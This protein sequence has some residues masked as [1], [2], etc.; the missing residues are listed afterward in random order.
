MKKQITYSL[1]II[2]LIAPLFLF[3]CA[4]AK[5]TGSNPV[6]RAASA[7]RL[8]NQGNISDSYIKQFNKEMD[9]ALSDINSKL[10][11]I[12]T[13]PEA[14]ESVADSIQD[15]I[16]LYDEIYILQKTYP[17]GLLGKKQAAYFDFRD[18]RPLKEEA[19]KRS[20]EL[21]YKKALSIISSSDS[22]SSLI[23]ALD[24]LKKA[25]TYSSHIDSEINSL[26][27]S[28]SYAAALKLSE[29]NKA[30]DLKLAYSLFIDTALWIPGYKDAADQAKA[31]RKKTALAI[32]TDGDKEAQK[33]TYP[34]IRQGYKLY[35]EAAEYDETAAAPKIKKGEELLTIR[36]GVLYSGGQ[37]NYPDAAVLK[38]LIAD[39]VLANQDG[40]MFAETT[41][42]HSP[43]SDSLFQ[44]LMNSMSAITGTQGSNQNIYK[45]FDILLVPSENFNKVVE[46]IGTPNRTQEKITK[47]FCQM[48]TIQAGKQDYIEIKEVS[49][50][51]Y[52][53]QLQ[54]L[55][56][57]TRQVLLTYWE[58]TGLI[59][60]DTQIVELQIDNSYDIFDLRDK[61]SFP[62]GKLERNSQKT[63]HTFIKTTFSG[64][65]LMRPKGL[66][67]D[68]F[69]VSGRYKQYNLKINELD[70][71]YQI[72]GLSSNTLNANGLQLCQ[73]IGKLTY[74]P[75][76]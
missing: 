27:A 18:F 51:E 60:T 74:K 59:I 47:Y 73:Q 65:E 52:E 35:K 36:V 56:T 62:L 66:R 68:D 30:A 41:F 6:Q 69:Y 3:S 9:Q 11:R 58:E 28:A 45:D 46:N 49:Q 16:I 8:L 15:W 39:K 75:K 34:G 72:I 31:I 70:N 20:A 29:S 1:L 43:A 71:P 61:T 50:N 25:K 5:I 2:L 55:I 53:N 57:D 22:P 21:H 48:R 37:K 4:S 42:L 54:D 7:A 64:S 17:S 40:P 32:I 26:G 14:Y 13:D 19:N 24:H 76:S 38:K 63:V 23:T 67:N 12:E 10:Y 33:N 44:L